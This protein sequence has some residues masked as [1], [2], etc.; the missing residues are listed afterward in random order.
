MKMPKI[1]IFTGFNRAHFKHVEGVP[2]CLT[3]SWIK[4]RYDLWYKWTWQSIRRQKYTDWIYCMCCDVASK[5]ITDKYFGQIRDKRFRLCY[6]ETDQERMIMRNIA[7]NEDYIVNVRIDSDDMYHPKAILEL[8]I[9]CRNSNKEWYQWQTGYGLRYSD[10]KMKQYIPGHKS[11]PFF[12]HKYPVK[13]WIE[14]GII[15]EC[16]HGKVKDFKP[17][18]MPKD[19]IIV[20]IGEDNTSTGIRSSCFKKPIEGITKKNILRHWGII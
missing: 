19:R 9:K 12:A 15:K 2:T 14:K 17:L 1:V 11:G 6:S 5:E 8:S 20:G 3:E 13:K 18:I 10:L 7:K 4:S 16:Q